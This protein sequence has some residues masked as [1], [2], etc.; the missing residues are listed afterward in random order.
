MAM[1]VELTSAAGQRRF[2]LNSA[3]FPVNTPIMFSRR[4]FLSTLGLGAAST[5]GLTSYGFAIEPRFR[6][7][8]TPYRLTPLGWPAGGRRLRI[9]AIADIHACEPWMPLSRI[10]HIVDTANSL[11]PDIVV[12]LGDYMH[13]AFP[14]GVV[15]S[16]AWGRSLGRLKAPLGVHAVL[17]NHDWWQDPEGVRSGLELSGIRVLENDALQLPFHGGKIWLAGLGDQ[18]AIHSEDGFDGVD[19]LPATLARVQGDS[20]PLILMAH[21]PDIFVDVPERVTITLSGHT[22]GGQVNLPFIGRPII[23]SRYGQRFAYG[24]IIE[25][26]R[27]LLVSSGLGLSGLPIRFMVP[28]EIAVL[29]LTSLKT[30]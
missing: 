27:H 14:S 7:V 28:P 24:H 30:A 21:E 2:D 20:D 12:L 23:P 15:P 11:E 29:T 16:G 17:G 4:A 13:G 26:E 6:L 22:H 18:L 25:N 10:E 9:A 8:V 1:P 5:I 19:D 3:G